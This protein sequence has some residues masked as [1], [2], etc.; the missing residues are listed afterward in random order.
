MAEI[1][2]YRQKSI[3]FIVLP[4]ETKISRFSKGERVQ[5]FL[6]KSPWKTPIRKTFN[7]STTAG[8]FLVKLWQC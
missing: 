2:Q 8:S 6:E 5:G 1:T 7:V 3:F 4:N